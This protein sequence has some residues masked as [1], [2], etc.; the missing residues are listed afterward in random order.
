MP[1]P[2]AKPSTRIYELL[3]TTDLENITFNQFQGVAEK[4]FA[5]Q[6]AED[7]LRRIV[8]VNLARLSVVGEWTG[9]TSAGG[10]GA[11]SKLINPK[12]VTPT[13]WTEELFQP[14]YPLNVTGSTSTTTSS[15]Y[16]SY[17][18]YFPFYANGDGKITDL[19]V[20]VT[21]APTGDQTALDVA[22]YDSDDEGWPQTKIGTASIDITAINE[23]LSTTI[24][25]TSTDSMTLEK[26]GL[27][28]I[29][30]KENGTTGFARLRAATNASNSTWGVGDGGVNILT[31]VN[32]IA[33]L[34]DPPPAT[35]SNASDFTAT[36]TK[37]VIIAGGVYS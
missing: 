26:G 27:Y 29:G 4:I 30:Y 23:D 9:L 25:E 2:D 19:R 15:T 24:T 10:G 31:V 28:W 20:A 17:Y 35:W 6:G 12:D 22:I 13:T 16:R 21:A 34:T 5:E 18:W 36:G 33:S 14:M 8:L 1:L 37:Q 3:K 7:E 32:C 11:Y